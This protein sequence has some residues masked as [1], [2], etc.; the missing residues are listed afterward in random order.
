MGRNSKKNKIRLNDEESLNHLIQETYNDACTQQIDADKAIKELI[1]QTE[2][3]DVDDYTKIA[4]ERANL[5]KIKDLAI[6]AKIEISKLQTEV[7]KSSKKGL[8]D[9][10]GNEN[11]GNISKDFEEVRRILKE[12]KDTINKVKY[13][14]N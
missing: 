9:D 13:D 4:K 6:R 7:I 8:D 5:L 12:S 14:A 10:S 3:A 2:P 11:I 1:T